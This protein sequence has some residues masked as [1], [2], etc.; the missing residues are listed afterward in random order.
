ALPLRRLAAPAPS[1]CSACPWLAAAPPRYFLELSPREREIFDLV[2]S[3]LT[4]RECAKLMRVGTKTAENHRARMMD[5]LG[6]RNI[7]EL[8]RYAWRHG[9]LPP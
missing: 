8:F 7:V 4:T 6:V 2:L 3:G 9:L 1:A 5:K